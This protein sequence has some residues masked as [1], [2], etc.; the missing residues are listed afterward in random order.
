VVSIT[1]NVEIEC[2]QVACAIA[3]YVEGTGV[4]PAQVRALDEHL[5]I[6]PE[7]SE[8]LA[9]LGRALLCIM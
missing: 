3:S 6:C 8:E 2:K 7:C 1:Q 4:A 9:A 5:A